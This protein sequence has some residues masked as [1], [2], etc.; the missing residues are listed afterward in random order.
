MSIRARRGSG[1]VALF[2][3]GEG[4]FDWDSEVSAGMD[5]WWARMAFVRAREYGGVCIV[6]TERNECGE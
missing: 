4:C 6:K 1:S 2:C 3:G 5:F